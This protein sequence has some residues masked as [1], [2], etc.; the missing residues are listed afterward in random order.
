MGEKEQ[1]WKKPRTPKPY[2]RNKVRKDTRDAVNN[3][4][5][6]RKVDTR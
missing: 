5:T 1:Y 4:K 6:K 3:L 2:K